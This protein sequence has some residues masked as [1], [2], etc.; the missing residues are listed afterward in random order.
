MQVL[1]NDNGYAR[2]GTVEGRGTDARHNHYLMI[3]GRAAYV[4]DL[5]ARVTPKQA[6]L[7]RQQM[8]A[9]RGYLTPFEA[10]GWLRAIE[11]GYNWQ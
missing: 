7:L 11:H 5:L 1:W 3:D 4:E 6:W 9:A 8:S 2:I 10:V